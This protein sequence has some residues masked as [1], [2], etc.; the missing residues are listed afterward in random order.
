MPCVLSSLHPAYHGPYLQTDAAVLPPLPS[1]YPAQTPWNTAADS[2]NPESYKNGICPCSGYLL[3]VPL[4]RAVSGS[5]PR[6]ALQPH[7]ICLSISYNHPFFVKGKAKGIKKP[8]PIGKG[9]ILLSLF[10]FPPLV[11]TTSSSKGWKDSFPLSC[12]RQHPQLSEKIFS[13]VQIIS[14]ILPL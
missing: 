13:Y 2:D 10:R 7:T 8:F 9:L 12:S 14:H 5:H 1:Q 11:L 4:Q 6:W 3:P